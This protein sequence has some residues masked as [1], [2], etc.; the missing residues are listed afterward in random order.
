MAAMAW[1][2][3]SLSIIL[4]MW[5]AHAA[6]A[7]ASYPCVNDA[8][9]PYQRGVSFAPL[10]DGRAWG[11]TA[12]VTVAADGTIWAYDRCGANSC[13]GSPLDPIIAFSPDGKVRRHFGGGLFQMPHGL[14]VDDAGNV[15]VTDNAAKDG[16]GMQVYK[17]SPQGQILMTLGK[18]G[19]G[20]APDGFFQPNAVAIASNGDIFVAQG[21]T[22]RGDKS[23]ILVFSPEG[24]FIRSFGGKGSGPGELDVPHALAFD[25]KGRL[26]VGDRNHNRIARFDRDGSYLGE[27]KQFSRPSAIVV[28]RDQTIYVGDSESQSRD[29]AA[30]A[31]NPGC[32][33]GIRFGKLEDARVLGLIPDQQPMSVSS[34]AEGVGVDKEGNVFG[35]EVGPRD[36]KKYLKK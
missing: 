15:W 35:A 22:A 8:P 5:G 1:R 24:K 3:V 29:A 31:Y 6:L 30:Y 7:Q 21:H 33:K 2:L 14:T 17:F 23:L 32:E 34:T 4:A 13:A 12:G 26:L 9:D 20:E 19:G 11:S 36:L 10:P 28:T 25:A 16:R 27:W 18:P